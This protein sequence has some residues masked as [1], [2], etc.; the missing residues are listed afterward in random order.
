M[1]CILTTDRKRVL[2]KPPNLT[3]KIQKTVL[4]SGQPHICPNFKIIW[5][6]MVKSLTVALS[7]NGITFINI[8]KWRTE[9]F[10]ERKTLGWHWRRV[11][12]W[13]QNT[14]KYRLPRNRNWNQHYRDQQK[15]HG[16]LLVVVQVIYVL[17][18]VAK[19]DFQSEVVLV[20]LVVVPHQQL[21][22]GKRPE[23]GLLSL[24]MP[25]KIS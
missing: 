6:L 2:Q 20:V 18:F 12:F 19:G 15:H 3:K 10:N 8:W 21:A 16:T 7:N 14:Y 25:F 22:L 4:T 11:T 1:C 9:M 17:R 13:W 5:M 24:I 23:S